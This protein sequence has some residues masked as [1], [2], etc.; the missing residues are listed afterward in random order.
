ML[1]FIAGITKL[2]AWLVIHKPC[3]LKE[4][5][6]TIVNGRPFRVVDMSVPHPN[7]LT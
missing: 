6:I 2:V 4:A 5:R 1:V 3:V 7:I